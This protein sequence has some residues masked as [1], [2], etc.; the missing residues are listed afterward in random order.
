MMSF[1]RRYLKSPLLGQ[2]TTGF[3][4]LMHIRGQSYAVKCFYHPADRNEE[5]NAIK[6]LQRAHVP[7]EHLCIQ[8]AKPLLDTYLVLDYAGET[9]VTRLKRCNP[10]PWHPSAVAFPDAPQLVH[11]VMSAAAALAAAGMIHGDI[12][13]SNICHAKNRWMLIDFGLTDV[14]A[15]SDAHEVPHITSFIGP[16]GVRAP[17]CRNGYKSVVTSAT[18][19]FM[20]GATLWTALNGLPFTYAGLARLR[21][22]GLFDEE[23]T[24]VPTL[25]RTDAYETVAEYES[26]VNEY[27]MRYYNDMHKP[28]FGSYLEATNI[29]MPRLADILLR[30]M[31]EQPCN[32]ISAARALK[33]C[34]DIM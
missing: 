12:R 18:E 28:Y 24:E 10:L 2:G 9:L 5:L 19:V 31:L 20:C 23:L 16:S 3:V 4:R 21:K 8:T 29:R 14:L 26:R 15:P 32:R 1:G 22:L 27:A 6:M 13:P 33:L 17:E 34:K 25:P 7:A 11:D 30:C